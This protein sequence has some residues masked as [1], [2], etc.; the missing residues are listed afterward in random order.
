MALIN[1]TIAQANYELV[2]NRI[3]EILAMEMPSQALKNG[4]DYLNCTVGIERL[5]PIDKTE[6]PFINVQIEKGE[7]DYYTEIRRAGTYTFWVDC[8]Q[9]AEATDDDESDKIAQYKLQRTLGV[10]EHVLNHWHYRTLGFPA[11]SLSRVEVTELLMPDSRQF[12]NAPAA[13]MG[14]AVVRVVVEETSDSYTPLPLTDFQTQVKLGLGDNGYIFSGPNIPVIPPPQNGLIYQRPFW[15]GQT[16][17]YSLYD[18]GYHYQN[19]TYDYAPA[20]NLLQQLDLSSGFT[21]LKH[22]NIFNNFNRFTDETGAQDYTN[23]L[24]ID[25]LTGLM[26]KRTRSLTTY[27]FSQSLDDV[28]NSTFGGFNDWRIPTNNEYLSIADYSNQNSGIDYPPFSD[29]VFIEQWSAETSPSETTEGLTVWYNIKSFTANELVVNTN[30]HPKNQV[31]KYWQIR[32]HL[33]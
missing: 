25:H 16:I 2:R 18:A 27:S 14:R 32:N 10:V 6:G 15:G 24:V 29:S 23:E 1:E 8:Y 31:L 21:I 33:Y 20:G 19:G 26:W 22:E 11:P 17:Q 4:L 9:R 5:I 13:I 28:H 30:R 7:Y 12:E 3:G